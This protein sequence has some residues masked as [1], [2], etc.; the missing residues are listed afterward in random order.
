[1]TLSAF[2]V[3]R[4]PRLIACLVLLYILPQYAFLVYTT[5]NQAYRPKDIRQVADAIQ[6]A[7]RQLGIADDKL[8][9]Y[10]DYGLWFAHPHYYRA[11]A[12]STMEEANDADLYLCYD[13]SLQMRAMSPESIFYCP[14]LKQL[15]PLRLLSTTLVRNNTLYLYARR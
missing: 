15:L 4:R 7:S 14:D 5:R 1:M 9:I 8:R 10:G 6:N 13:H 2:E 3:E 11:A 12:K